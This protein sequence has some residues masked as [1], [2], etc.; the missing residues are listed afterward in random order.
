[1]A[2]IFKRILVGKPLAS[3]EQD[4]QAPGK[5]TALAVVAPDAT[6]STTDATSVPF[7]ADRV[8]VTSPAEPPGSGPIPERGRS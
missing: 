8:P 2:S 4:H 5:P 6:S 7:P 1:M 3:S